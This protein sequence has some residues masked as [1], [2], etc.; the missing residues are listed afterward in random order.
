[1]MLLSL[2]LSNTKRA[3][4][5]EAFSPI[6]HA[7]IPR[8]TILEARNFPHDLQEM[9]PNRV[10]AEEII[11]KY[12]PFS[13]VVN[14]QSMEVIEARQLERRV[15]LVFGVESSQQ[16]CKHGF[17]RAFVRYPV[18]DKKVQSGMLRL[19]CPHLVK[20][21]DSLE[22]NGGVNEMNE[23]LQKGAIGS[24]LQ[25]NLLDV[26]VAWKNIRNVSVSPSDE[27]AILDYLG[28]D[29]ANHFLQSGIIGISLN[30]TDDVKCLHAH[31]ADEI[32]RGCNEIGKATLQ[33]LERAGVDPLGC[34][35]ESPLSH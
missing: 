16:R 32:L 7:L 8:A 9:R 28:Q 31:V 2:L 21:I 4:V 14:N 24:Q 1:M 26:N 20:A 30:K 12:F 22:K 35:G 6:S 29:G 27:V 25:R 19:S 15:P 33:Q 18:G 17:P 11:K 5:L 23:L 34:G 3:I 13:E 10:N